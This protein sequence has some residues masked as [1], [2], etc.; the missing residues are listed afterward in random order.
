MRVNS[1][2]FSPHTKILRTRGLERSC[3][4]IQRIWRGVLARREFSELFFKKVFRELQGHFCSAREGGEHSDGGSTTSSPRKRSHSVYTISLE[5]A[6]EE[7]GRGW[8]DEKSPT[9]ESSRRSAGVSTP[10]SWPRQLNFN[11]PSVS[12]P[13]NSA[14]RAPEVAEPTVNEEVVQNMTLPE[15]HEVRA[16]EMRTRRWQTRVC[17]P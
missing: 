10:G 14:E 15:L 11:E 5:E 13:S 9:S 7:A 2:V 3:V 17:P 12:S 8:F 6:L 4:I 16:R 1:R